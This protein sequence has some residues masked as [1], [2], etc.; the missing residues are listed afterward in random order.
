MISKK[1]HQMSAQERGLIHYV[2]AH[3]SKG[4]GGKQQTTPPPKPSNK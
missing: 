4:H 1:D 2:V 3:V